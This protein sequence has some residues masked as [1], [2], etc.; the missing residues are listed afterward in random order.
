MR[1]STSTTQGRDT[2]NARSHTLDPRTTSKP[3][4]SSR[5]CTSTGPYKIPLQSR[6]LSPSALQVLRRAR[7]NSPTS[8]QSIFTQEWARRAQQQ[9]FKLI[10]ELVFRADI[11]ASPDTIVV[12]ASFL[13]NCIRGSKLLSA[14][15]IVR[16]CRHSVSGIPAKI[17]SQD[18]IDAYIAHEGTRVLNRMMNARMLNQLTSHVIP[19]GST[20]LKLYGRT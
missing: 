4:S 15:Q 13:T 20:I 3:S 1:S 5:G 6:V 7:R 18:M 8:T 12:R 17:V 11:K 10:V 14:F 2:E 16:G 9:R 19:P